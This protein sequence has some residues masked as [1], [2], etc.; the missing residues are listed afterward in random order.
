MSLVS[1][2]FSG[3][4]C[5]SDLLFLEVPDVFACFVHFLNIFF[6]FPWVVG[7]EL[8]LIVLFLGLFGLFLILELL[9]LAVEDILHLLAELVLVRV[10][11]LVCQL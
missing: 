9:H 7:G 5:I 2:V 4:L 10:V 3:L 6:H 1:S 8:L 11:L